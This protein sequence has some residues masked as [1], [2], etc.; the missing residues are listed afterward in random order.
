MMLL[1]ST[2]RRFTVSIYLI[3]LIVLRILHIFGGVFWVGG[4]IV[5]VAF[6][7][8]TARATAPEGHKFVQYLVGRGR[9]SLFMNVVSALTVLSG[10]LLYW[11]A[12]GGLQISWMKFGPGLGYTI[13][14]VVAI[15]VYFLGLLMIRPRADHLG[16][17]GRQIG[18]AGGVPTSAQLAELHKV[19]HELT[20]IGRVD[21]V[22][23][24]VA[25]LAMATARYW[26]IF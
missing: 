23:L 7:E 18:A 17:L 20:L 15:L 14:T 16:G 3:Y 6:I 10:A 13:G 25:L 21:F 12:S 24:A 26:L 4:A 11:H 5:H 2:I 19:N 22:L 8:P 9:F 1:N